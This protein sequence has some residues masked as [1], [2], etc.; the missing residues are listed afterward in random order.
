M[1]KH[2]FAMMTLALSSAGMAQNLGSGPSAQPG[3]AVPVYGTSRASDGTFVGGTSSG[4]TPT[5]PGGIAPATGN[6]LDG[7]HHPPSGDGM[8]AGATTGQGSNTAAA[9]PAGATRFDPSSMPGWSMMTPQ[10]QQAY[11]DKMNSVTTLG[12]CRALNAAAVAQLQNR[13]RAM[14]QTLD[15]RQSADPCTAMQKQATQQR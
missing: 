8:A 4:G 1:K 6:T 9:T 12:Q 7:A 2:F 13:A 10:E 11:S 15:A 5:A 14:G 3:T